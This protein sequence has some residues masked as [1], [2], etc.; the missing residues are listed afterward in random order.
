MA[1]STTTIDNGGNSKRKVALLTEITCQD[2]STKLSK[3]SNE[4]PSRRSHR[5]LA[6][7]F[8]IGSTQFSPTSEIS[9]FGHRK[10]SLAGYFTPFPAF[11]QCQQN[12]FITPFFLSTLQTQIPPPP[13]SPPSPPPY[14]TTNN[15]TD[16]S[17]LPPPPLSSSLSSS[18]S[19]MS[20]Y[21]CGFP[22][23][24]L[25]KEFGYSKTQSTILLLIDR[26]SQN[27]PLK[28]GPFILRFGRNKG[29]ERR[30]TT[31]ATTTG[32]GGVISKNDVHMV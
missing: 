13:V 22:F 29:G 8:A 26:S 12:T 27:C 31:T 6:F 14:L 7:L 21:T 11:P 25:S 3:S 16:S 20:N 2:G 10:I 9:Y 4:A 30:L 23:L 24:S 5:C 17:P 18:P 28:L 15:L 19:Y 1:S 32:G